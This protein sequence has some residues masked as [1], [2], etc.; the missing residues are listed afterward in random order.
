MGPPFAKFLY[1]QKALYWI[2][3]RTARET[4]T[5]YCVDEIKGDFS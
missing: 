3:S 1:Y 4:F 5:D 2:Q